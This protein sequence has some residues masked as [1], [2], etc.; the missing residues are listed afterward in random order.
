[1]PKKIISPRLCS[2]DGCNNKH[3]AK[4]FCNIHYRRQK[5]HGRL[6]TI[7]RKNGEGSKSDYHKFL[8]NGKKIQMHRIIAEKVLGKTLPKG[9]IVHHVDGNGL[10]N[11]NSNLV[12]CPNNAYH[13]FL[14]QRT[15]AYESC[16]HA[17]WRKCKICKKYDS[18]DNIYITKY[19]KS[20][21]KACQADYDHERWLKKGKYL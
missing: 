18:P 21:H 19:N 12:I 14:H 3:Y 5:Q 11:S 20:Y 15:R 1:M 16:G 17:D 13:L 7:K 2:V 4:A 6:H 9:A 8:I 10:N